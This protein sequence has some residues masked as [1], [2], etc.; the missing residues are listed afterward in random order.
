[1]V[2]STASVQVT[3]V[4]LAELLDDEELVQRV[5]TTQRRGAPH[6][7]RAPSQFGAHGSAFASP[8]VRHAEDQEYS[9]QLRR[10]SPVPEVNGNGHSRV[11]VQISNITSS[12]SCILAL[13]TLGARFGIHPVT[14]ADLH[15]GG[16]GSSSDSESSE[17]EKLEVFPEYLL[18]ALHAV[19]HPTPTIY[20][21]MYEAA[22]SSANEENAARAKLPNSSGGGW[23]AYRFAKSHSGRW[24]DR[25]NTAQRM[26][27]NPASIT[28]ETAS[29]ANPFERSVTSSAGTHEIDSGHEVSLDVD[30]YSEPL[31]GEPLAI[32]NSRLGAKVHRDSILFRLAGLRTTPIFIVIF[33]HLVMSFHRARQHSVTNAVCRR[34]QQFSESRSESG[35]WVVHAMLDTITNSLRPSVESSEHE[36]DRLE[37]L[38]Y[39]LSG[40]GVESDQ[41]LK[42]MGLIR[43]RLTALKQHLRSKLSILTSLI[44]KDWR[45]LL[46]SSFQTPYLRDVQDHVT[47]MLI[48][49]ESGAE[50]LAALQDTHLATVQLR[51]ARTSNQG[52]VVMQRFSAVAT[53]VLPLSLIAG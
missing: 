49:V 11:W 52:N 23:R 26:N 7:S 5:R 33:P 21:I 17:R 1:V 25:A 47:T 10:E 18:L 40:E 44:D 19:V 43:R 48:K 36:V 37:A 41:L 34:L 29:D 31:P 8:H 14:I 4:S 27:T 15:G 28:E 35:A 12:E 32:V 22:L 39:A 2:Q 6:S 38:I 42:R 13:Q 20:D 9:P 30:A 50:M 45:H 3:D 53:I 16:S 24:S 51:T 46:F